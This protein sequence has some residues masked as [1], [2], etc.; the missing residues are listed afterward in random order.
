[1]R[2]KRILY[3]ELSDDIYES[4]RITKSKLIFLG[5]LV[6]FF[7]FILNLSLEE[8]ANRLLTTYL[9]GNPQCPIQF[10]KVE[11]G[12]FPPK[13]ALKKMTILGACF[14]QPSNRLFVDELALSPDWPSIS[15]LGL[16]MSVQIKAEDSLI[17][18]SPIISFFGRYIEIEKSTINAKIFHILTSDDK[19]PIAG[20]IY[21]KGFLKFES[22]I[23]TDGNIQMD[24]NNFHFPSQR[25]SGFDLPLIQLDKFNLEALFEKAGE[26]K[27]KKIEIGKPGKQIEINLAGKLQIS[28]SSFVSSIINLEGSMKLSPA[29][30]TNFSYLTSFILPP[31]HTDGKYQMKINGPLL[32][33]GVPQFQ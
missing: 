28:K 20:K 9:T 32:N 31:G 27:I 16:R 29:F 3:N 19:S 17:K 18:L 23:L 11:L 14:N 1:M 21:V 5:I 24:S 2:K 12:Y 10:E 33:P 26:M 7:S 22:D 6:L 8:K 25:I 13:L 30:M 4:T 15:K